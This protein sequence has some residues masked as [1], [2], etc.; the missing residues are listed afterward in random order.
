MQFKT[1]QLSLTPYE[2]VLHTAYYNYEVRNLD[3]KL[4]LKNAVIFKLSI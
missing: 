4:P 2:I 3:L 1:R